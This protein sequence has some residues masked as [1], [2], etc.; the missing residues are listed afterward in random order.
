V[1]QLLVA[2][3]G[4]VRRILTAWNRC[5]QL[6]WEERH[7]GVGEIDGPYIDIHVDLDLRLLIIGMYVYI[8]FYVQEIS[9]ICCNPLI[10]PRVGLW[11]YWWADSC[12]ARCV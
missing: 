5:G 7:P 1:A 6:F 11:Q 3:I 4:S 9:M 10:L 12:S 2:L 8:I